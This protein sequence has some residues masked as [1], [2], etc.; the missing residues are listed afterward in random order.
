MNLQQFEEI[1]PDTII[2]SGLVE[3]S[4]NGIFMSRQG[5]ML[6]WVAVKGYGDDFSFYVGWSHKSQHEI[7]QNGDKTSNREKIKE[8]TGF[9]DEIMKKYRS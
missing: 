3:N 4:P 5:G 9:S 7:A 2:S 1:E 8:L 6:R